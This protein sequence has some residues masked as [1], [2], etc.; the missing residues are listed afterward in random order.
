[1]KIKKSNSKNKSKRAI[2][3]G[4]SSTPTESD[5]EGIDGEFIDRKKEDTF[6]TEKLSSHLNT[7]REKYKKQRASLIKESDPD[8]FG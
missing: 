5:N 4:D 1:M 2:D 3:G 6:K 7:V 8:D